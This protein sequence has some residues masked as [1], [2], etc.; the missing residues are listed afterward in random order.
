[1]ERPAD[2]GWVL[3]GP[4]GG[5]FPARVDGGGLVNPAGVRWSLDW[6]VGAGSR[7]YFSAQEP[8]IRQG[9][10]GSGP[11]VETRLRVPGGDIVHSVY[12]AMAA[13]REVTVVEVSNET[14]APVG[15]GLAIRPYSASGQPSNGSFL[16]SGFT[17]N[18]QSMSDGLTVDD[19]GVWADSHLIVRFD[20][21]PG[22]V[23]VSS[24]TDLAFELGQGAADGAE[25]IIPGAE[26]SVA[27]P[28]ESTNA[29]AVFALTHNTTLRFLVAADPNEGLAL[30][31]STTGIDVSVAPDA[32]AVSNGWGAVLGQASRLKLPDE[33]FERLA[34]G[35]RSRLLLNIPFLGSELVDAAPGAGSELAALALYGHEIEVGEL[36]EPLVSTFPR[37]PLRY[38]PDA[39]VEVVESLDACFD[40]LEL[41]PDPT[42]LEYAMQLT[43]LVERSDGRSGSRPGGMGLLGRLGLKSTKARPE[44]VENAPALRRARLSLSRLAL[45]AG[46]P[47]AARELE[48]LASDIGTGAATG[49]GEAGVTDRKELM[50]GLYDELVAFSQTASSAGSWGGAGGDS[51]ASAARFLLMLRRLLVD[52]SEAGELDVLVGYPTAWR[53]GNLEIHDLVTRWGRLAV[54]VRWHGYRPALFWQLDRVPRR[55]PD[56]ISEDEPLEPVVIRCSALD[57]DWS[58]TELSGDTLLSGSADELGGPPA[59]GEG[60]V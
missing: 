6:L 4:F 14:S 56:G 40:A 15:L 39:A 19:H 43:H 22:Q 50:T 44:D 48:A 34:D 58:T 41:I 9:R 5:R 60:F 11:V 27:R 30:L 36:L 51:A 21:R 46:Q 38:G 52:D 47:D 1:M 25:A 32:E 45:A 20:L 55:G 12:G 49:V 42:A 7:W 28:D 17:E 57:A 29:V 24:K 59:P 16:G 35:A 3:V 26:R 10:L 8:S 37:G 13:G 2:A 54:A 18:E 33:G 23:G 31:G 53:G